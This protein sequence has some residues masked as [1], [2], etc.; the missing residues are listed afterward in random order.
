MNLF[1]V[2]LIAVSIATENKTQIICPGYS[3]EKKDFSFIKHHSKA[4]TLI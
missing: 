3:R 1:F 2:L 4:N